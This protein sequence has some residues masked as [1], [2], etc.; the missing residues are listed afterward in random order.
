MDRPGYQNGFTEG[1]AERAGAT[2]R[3]GKSLRQHADLRGL[4]YPIQ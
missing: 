1:A 3:D 4:F 2:N